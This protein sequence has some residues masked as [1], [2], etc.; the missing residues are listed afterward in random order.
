VHLTLCAPMI[1]REF[2]LFLLYLEHVISNFFWT[3]DRFHNTNCSQTPENSLL[4]WKWG[5]WQPW[6]PTP[7]KTYSLPTLSIN[8]A[9]LHAQFF[10]IYIKGIVHPK[11]KILSFTHPHVVP[12]LCELNELNTKEAILKNVG[13]QYPIDFQLLVIQLF[14]YQ[15]SLK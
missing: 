14:D 4:P 2:S 7:I 8:L 5:S 1:M 6:P 3:K 9:V 11:K 12:N 13:N 15:H 10:F